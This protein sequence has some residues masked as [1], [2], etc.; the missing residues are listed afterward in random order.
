MKLI[1]LYR[2]PYVRRVAVSLNLLGF[3]YENEAITPFENPEAVSPHNPLVRIPTLVLDDGEVLVESYAIL[4]TLDD[5]SPAEKRLL[6]PSG[7]ARKHA[8]KLAAI[9][10]GTMDKTV[11]AVYEG[12]FHPKEKY[13]KPWVEHNEAQAEGGLAYLN[14]AVLKADVAEEGWLADT[15]R[16]GQAD[17]SATIA[18]SFA[19]MARPKLGVAEKFPALKA[20]AERM[21]A[22]NAF[23]SVAP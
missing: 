11:W 3:E 6:P 5:M 22:T 2:S 13:H 19:L 14:D 23:S 21:E 15:D 17:V 16:I 10:T 8:L 4:D 12:R 18:Y 20:F 7:D 1:G 9:A